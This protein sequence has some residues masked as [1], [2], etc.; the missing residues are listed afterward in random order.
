VPADSSCRTDVCHRCETDL[1][2]GT[3]EYDPEPLDPPG[4]GYALLCC[5]RPVDDV[6]LDL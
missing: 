1:F 6:T 3:L 4:D 5:G 2:T